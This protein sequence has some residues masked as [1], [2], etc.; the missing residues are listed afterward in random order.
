[1]AVAAGTSA[2]AVAAGTS[3]TGKVGRLVTVGGIEVAGVAGWLVARGRLQAA[4][5]TV[6]RN[7]EDI[8]FISNQPP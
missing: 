6:I 5:K 3:V 7:K 1:V 8:F 2:V 4:S